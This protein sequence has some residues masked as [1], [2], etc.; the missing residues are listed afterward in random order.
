MAFGYFYGHLV[1]SI[2]RFGMFWYQEKS[3][4][5]CVWHGT[6]KIEVGA[7]DEIILPIN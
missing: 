7:A 2:P 1:N 3:G 6:E 5:P 4:N